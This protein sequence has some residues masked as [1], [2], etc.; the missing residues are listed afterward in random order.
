MLLLKE[1]KKIRTKKAIE[2]KNTLK[3]DIVKTL[4]NEQYD[5]DV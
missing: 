3:N 2:I 4:T 1:G 5:E